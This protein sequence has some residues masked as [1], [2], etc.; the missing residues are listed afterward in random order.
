MS[1]LRVEKCLGQITGAL[2]ALVEAIEAHQDQ[3][4]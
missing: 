2:E 3:I 4:L 1:K